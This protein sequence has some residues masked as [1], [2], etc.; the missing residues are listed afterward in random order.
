MTTE[1]DTKGKVFTNVVAKKPVL[2]IVQAENYR[3]KG[4]LYVAPGERIKDELN[5]S[6]EFIALTDAVVYDLSGKALY[7]SKFLTLN[8]ASIIWLIPV[9]ELVEKGDQGG[10]T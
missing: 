10:L 2:V 9:N 7:C 4:N 1:F 8:S 5:S 3:I 6:N